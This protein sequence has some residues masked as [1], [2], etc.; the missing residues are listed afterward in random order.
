MCVCVCWGQSRPDGEK[1]RKEEAS[2]RRE[3]ISADVVLVR[4]NKL[5]PFH[6]PTFA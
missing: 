6:P 1:E 2:E 4:I 3:G 5:Q